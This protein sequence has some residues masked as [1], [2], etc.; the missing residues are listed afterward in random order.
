MQGLS[1]FGTAPFSVRPA[2]TQKKDV[3]VPDPPDSG[4]G[5]ANGKGVT[6]RWGLKEAGGKPLAC[7]SCTRR[8][9]HPDRL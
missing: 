8:E 5:A 1:V 6:V 7:K 9:C 2:G 3:K 4:K